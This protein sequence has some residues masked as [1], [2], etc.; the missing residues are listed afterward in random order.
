MNSTL[1]LAVC[2]A[3]V[4]TCFGQDASQLAGEPSVKAALEA[5]KREEPETLKAQ[6]EVCEIPAPP[7]KETQRGLELQRRFKALGLVNVRIDKA[8]NVIGSCRFE[9][10]APT[11]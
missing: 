6:A 7:F 5:A 2:S 1:M 8:G 11:W 10:R 4:L 3:A 9:R